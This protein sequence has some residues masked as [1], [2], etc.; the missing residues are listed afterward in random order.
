MFSKLKKQEPEIEGDAI[1]QSIKRIETAKK[2]Y[3]DQ[4]EYLDKLS[5]KKTERDV[6]HVKRNVNMV[7]TNQLRHLEIATEELS[8][9]KSLQE[10]VRLLRAELRARFDEHQ[11]RNLA[12]RQASQAEKLVERFHQI[13]AEESLKRS[14]MASKF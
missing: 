11:D 12:A 4:V 14:N 3:S 13:F 6:N 8:M 7:H 5:S 2:R 9:V 1:A 10:D